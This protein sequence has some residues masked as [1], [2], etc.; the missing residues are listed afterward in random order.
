VELTVISASDLR[1]ADSGLFGLTNFTKVIF[2]NFRTK[3]IL[4][5][6]QTKIKKKTLDPFF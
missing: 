1:A 6:F 5:N 2:V 4:V 3:A